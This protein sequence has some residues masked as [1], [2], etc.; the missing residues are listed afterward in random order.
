MVVS[1]AGI[2][3]YCAITNTFLFRSI[4]IFTKNLEHHGVL[5]NIEVGILQRLQALLITFFP[6]VDA[7]VYLKCEPQTA[8]QRIKARNRPEEKEITLELL[9]ELH[10]LHEDW[11]KSNF[12][13]MAPKCIEIFDTNDTFEQ[14][15]HVYCAMF[16]KFVEQ[17][18][19][20]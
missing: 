10:R 19:S 4:N 8:L 6:K 18:K 11:E 12:V 1:N 2:R 17:W 7:V 14:L 13:D 3:F 20:K 5:S 9:E 15:K 16:H